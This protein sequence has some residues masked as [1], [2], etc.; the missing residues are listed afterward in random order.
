MEL[1]PLQNKEVDVDFYRN[2]YVDLQHMTDEKLVEHYILFGKSE[3]RQANNLD[4]NAYREYN[5]DLHHMTDEQLVEH[6]ILYG[7]NEDRQSNYNSY[8][9]YNMGPRKHIYENKPKKHIYENKE[10]D[11][12]FYRNTYFDLRHMTDKQLVEHYILYGKSEGRQSNNL[13]VNAYREYNLDLQHM[14]DEQLVEHYVNFGENEGR[15]PSNVVNIVGFRNI[16]CSFNDIIYSVVKHLFGLGKK[17]RAFDI[18]NID[19]VYHSRNTIV[20]INPFDI[21]EKLLSKFIVKPAAMWFW[22]FKSVPTKFKE[23]EKYFSKIYVASDFCR[24]V[25][26]TNIT[27]PVEKIKLISKIHEYLDTIP[28][29]SISNKSLNNIINHTNNKIRYGY[30]FDF[31]SSVI[32]KNVLNLVKAFQHIHDSNKVLIL[33]MR[34]T[35]FGS[36]VNKLEENIYNEFIKIVRSNNNIFLIDEELSLLDLYKLYTYFDYYISPHCGEGYGITIHDNMI[37]GNMIISPYYSGET[38]FLEQG[39]FIELK[40]EEKEIEGLKEHPTYGQMSEYK[41]A[42]ISVDNIIDGI[43][44]SE[45]IEITQNMKLDGTYIVIDCQPLQHE[46]RGIGRYGTNLIN[47]II[48]KTSFMI[49]LLVNNFL[50]NKSLPNIQLR[51]GVEIVEVA[52]RNVINKDYHERNVYYSTNEYIYEKKLADIINTINP[53]IFLNISEFDRRKVLVNIDLLNK[54]IKTFSILY[55]LIP[56]KNNWLPSMDVRWQ[57]NYMKQ[58]DNLKKY[59]KLLSIS[60][61]TKEDCSDIFKNIVSIGTGV[62]VENMVFNKDQIDSTLQKFN[63]TKKYIFCQTCFGENKSFDLLVYQYRLLP[64]NVKNN[65]LLVLGSNIPSDYIEKH[66]IYDTNIIITGYLS[67]DDLW[68]LHD[69]AWLFVFPSSYEGFGIPPIESMYHNKPVIVAKKTSLIEIM[70][71]EKFMFN[72]HDNSCSHLICELYNDENLY[73]ECREYCFN[74]K[75]FFTWENIFINISDNAFSKYKISIILVLHNNKNWLNYIDKQFTEMGKKFNLD[76][77]YFIYEN[78][79]NEEFKSFLE[80][81]M[82]GKNGKLLSED[83]G[84]IKYD[85]IISKERGLHMNFIRNKNKLNHGDLNSDFV[86]LLDADV[87]FNERV[88]IQYINHLVTNKNISMITGYPLCRVRLNIANYKDYKE[89]RKYH[90]YDSL[91]FSTEKYNYLNNYNTCLLEKCINCIEW[92]N[93]SEHNLSIDKIDLIKDGDIVKVNS[94]FGCNAMI[95]TNIYNNV[96]WNGNYGLEETDHYGFCQEL[97]KFGDLIFDTNIKYIK[98]KDRN[99]SLNDKFVK[100]FDKLA[101]IPYYYNETEEEE[102]YYL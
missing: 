52:F 94:V 78:N 88:I 54:N 76:F 11:V 19:C 35:R 62:Y 56:L 41:G 61:F 22:E 25:F 85:S 17:V 15:Y 30:C 57:Q 45:L 63:I 37:L 70:R 64:D 96:I 92:R 3:G 24:E 69:N 29:H 81:F 18:S 31:N 48:K 98:H 79:S 1:E 80:K 43:K 47:T 60:D 39:K 67:E 82:D 101:E 100:C 14:T 8:N 33:K 87:Y 95:P 71:N 34:K 102:I 7:K 90:Y 4:V 10:V 38:D 75:N 16:N 66:E 13:D 97:K 28:S 27:I 68:I 9:N 74:R 49:K 6:Y 93:R 26:S 58:V 72:N 51:E 53:H 32:R 21:S 99:I 65:M 2:A 40:Y 12:D 89:I 86:L 44:N 59:D 46:V 84:V 55:D 20:C 5:L 23:Y 77:E 73:N 83:I 91:A 50:P 36:F 42:Y